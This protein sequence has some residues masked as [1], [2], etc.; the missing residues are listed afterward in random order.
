MRI[1]LNRLDDAFHFEAKNEDGNSVHMDAAEKIGGRN[2][3]ARPTQLVLMALAGCSGIDVISILKKQK[4]ELKDFKIEVDGEQEDL[5]NAAKA[6]TNAHVKFFLDGEV[7]EDKAK[8]AV[9]LSI[10]KYC[11]VEKI[12]RLSGAKITYEVMLNGK[13]IV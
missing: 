11:S 8:R 1:T 2:K 12:L 3:G 13:K 5:Q 7:D 6:F 10:E 4:V 9:S